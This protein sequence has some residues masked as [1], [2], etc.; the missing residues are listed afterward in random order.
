MPI[1]KNFI[2]AISYLTATYLIPTGA[3]SCKFYYLSQADP[4]GSLPSWLV[5]RASTV[6]APKVRYKI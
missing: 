2:R 3:N 1:K 4:G 6:L 5:N